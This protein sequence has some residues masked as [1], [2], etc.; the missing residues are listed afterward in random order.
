MSFFRFPS[1]PN[2]RLLLLKKHWDSYLEKSLWPWF[3]LSVTYL[4]LRWVSTIWISV[5]LQ[6]R[7]FIFEKCM[8]AHM[9]VVFVSVGST[10]AK[11]CTQQ[12]GWRGMRLSRRTFGS[13]GNEPFI[14]RGVLWNLLQTKYPI[15]SPMLETDTDRR[16]WTRNPKSP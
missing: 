5:A 8:C 1:V 2:K 4:F 12:Q 13:I 7:I 14:G 9:A 6:T 15:W 11:R 16:H 10:P 3:S